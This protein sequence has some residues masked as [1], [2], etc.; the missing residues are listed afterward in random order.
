[1]HP[2]RNLELEYNFINNGEV[3]LGSDQKMQLSIWIIMCR[4]CSYFFATG[5]KYP[6]AKVLKWL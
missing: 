4:A 2:I 3:I 5:A 6:D 1:M